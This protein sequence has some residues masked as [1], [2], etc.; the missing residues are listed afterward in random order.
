[1]TGIGEIES[2]EWQWIFIVS[3]ILLVI[4]SIPFLW[5]YG[6]A[7]P[8]TH[9]L[10]ILNN[11]ID[12]ASYLAKM[13]QGY[14]GSWLV[15]L[16]YTPEPH[17]GV[18]SYTFYLALGH[19]ARLLNLPLVLVFHV[20][21]LVGTVLMF[22]ALYR[23]VADWT[24]DVAQ[25]RLTWSLVVLG[26]GLGAVA[27]L[28]RVTTPDLL[29]MPEAFPLQAAYT[30]AHFPWSITMALMLAHVLV[31]MALRADRPS[32][33]LNLYSIFLATAALALG[34]MAPFVL[35]PL[36]LGYGA[37]L[38]WLW[39]R[40]R[41][42][43]LR[44]ASWGSIVLIFGLP[45][46]AYDF[47]I[48]TGAGPVFSAWMAQNLTPSPPVWHYLIAFGPLLI[49]A[50]I[51]LW[52]IRGDL[53]DPGYLFL[54]VWL[55]G[56]AVLLYAPI[57]L[58][59]R[60]SMGLIA[61]LGI[62]AGIG[63]RRVL[64]PAVRPDRR[65]FVTLA[66]SSACMITTIVAILLPMVGAMAIQGLPRGDYYFSGA[67]EQAALGWI[68]RNGGSSPLVLASPE[69]SL[70]LPLYGARV[71]YAHPF[72]TVDAARR[73]RAVLDFY[74]GA[75]CSVLTDEGVGWVIVGRRERALAGEGTI[76]PLPDE[77]A[78]TSPQGEVLI[79]DVGSGR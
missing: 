49:L 46:L 33:T 76:C 29:V 36:A 40:R 37:L 66:I 63:L 44:E 14:S 62:F 78:Y 54:L 15:T 17:H 69:L 32:P 35:V 22:L 26:S 28:F 58:Q 8:D 64:L 77:P 16:P 55:V 65:L 57:P 9:F 48:A 34:V 61:P 51:G 79:Y 42:F 4:I 6:V 56:G 3:A 19:L 41:A 52:G 30:N 18:I 7:L 1:M 13:Y 11:P 10:G 24:D 5:A 25:R 73:E 31:N 75:D 39:R 27:L 53:N 43:P 47:W 68:A 12:G 60:F 50:G 67:D 38:V 2:S 72:E 45:V 71:V 20:A 70:Q 74:R 21:R 23:F 59:R